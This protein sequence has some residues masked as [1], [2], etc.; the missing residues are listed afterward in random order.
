[1]SYTCNDDDDDYEEVAPH[2]GCPLLRALNMMITIIII[3]VLT[4]TRKYN[5]I[6]YPMNTQYIL[7]CTLLLH[8]N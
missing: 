4:P 8:L 2:K 6:V 5:A 3:T 1:M 7:L